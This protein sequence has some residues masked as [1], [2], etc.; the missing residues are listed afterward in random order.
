[1]PYIKWYTCIQYT[2]LKYQL[3]RSFTW[4]KNDDQD[5]KI[6]N[7][8]VFQNNLPIICFTILLIVYKMV[9]F[10]PKHI[11]FSK[12]KIKI[13][14]TEYNFTKPMIRKDEIIT[15]KSFNFELQIENKRPII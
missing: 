5:S 4:F 6:S 13:I 9:T 8:T 3:C 7:I 15:F 11:C 10:L 1:M 14:I 12:K 2:W